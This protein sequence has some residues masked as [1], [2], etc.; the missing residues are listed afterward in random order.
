MGKRR[1]AVSPLQAA[2]L[3]PDPIPPYVPPGDWPHGR[4]Y[5]P[6]EVAHLLPAP[7]PAP[8]HAACTECGG[9]LQGTR[10]AGGVCLNCSDGRGWALQSV[11][12]ER[13]RQAARRPW[14]RR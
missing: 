13:A 4:V 8:R 5:T 10:E 2:L 3:P 1:R 6:A 12:I 14:L 9:Y 7:A 11:E